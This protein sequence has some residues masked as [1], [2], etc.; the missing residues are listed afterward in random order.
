MTRTQLFKPSTAVANCTPPHAPLPQ[1][2]RL[3][4]HWQEAGNRKW[5]WKWKPGYLIQDLSVLIAKLNIC[6]SAT[7][8]SFKLLVQQPH[9]L[10]ISLLVKMVFF[11][12]ISRKFLHFLSDPTGCQRLDSTRHALPSQ[13]ASPGA[14]QV[15]SSKDTHT[16]TP[17][18]ILPS[19]YDFQM[20][21]S[22]SHLT[23]EFWN[24]IPQ[25][26]SPPFPALP[27]RY[28]GC[29]IS[30][31]EL[32]F[33]FFPPIAKLV[34]SMVS[35]STWP[36]SL[37]FQ[38]LVQKTHHWLLL[39]FSTASSHTVLWLFLLSMARIGRFS[40]T[41]LCSSLQSLFSIT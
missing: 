33:H 31:P 37:C 9:L 32:L 22:G 34:L 11:K 1:H 19:H 15:L 29:K 41:S 21:S 13:Y 5:T 25:C 18:R 4:L 20:C 7:V 39:H 6:S 17:S 36:V 28:L 26:C 35:P 40:P 24:C 3:N 27:N 14:L 8:W 30:T 16:L 12:L 2:S 23:S 10:C 38:C